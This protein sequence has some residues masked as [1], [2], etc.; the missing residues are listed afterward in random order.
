MHWDLFL[1]MKFYVP[2]CYRLIDSFM[3]SLNN[4]S[5]TKVKAKRVVP[6]QKLKNIEPCSSSGTSRQN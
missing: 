3:K 2:V 4:F 6:L 1:F 5:L